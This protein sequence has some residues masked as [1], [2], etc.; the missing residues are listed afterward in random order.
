MLSAKSV[1]RLLKPVNDVSD[2][3]IVKLRSVRDDEGH[4]ALAKR[5]PREIYNWS[6]E[7]LYIA[8][9]YALRH[10]RSAATIT[11]HGSFAYAHAPLILPDQMRTHLPYLYVHCRSAELFPV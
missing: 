9:L 1:S 8:S 11:F 7:G 4:L 2:D 5:L 3:L 6:M 10:I